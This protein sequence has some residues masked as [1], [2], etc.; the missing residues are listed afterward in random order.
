[1]TGAYEIKP[2]DLNQLVEETAETF[3][4]I[5]KQIVI[6]TE[7]AAD[8]FPVEADRGQIEQILLNLFVNAAEA[9]PD[10]G[11]LT[12]KTMNTTRDAIADKFYDPQSENYVLLMVTDSGM[13]MDEETMEHIFDPF[14]TTKPMGQGTGLGLASAYNI[15]K[16]HDGYIEVESTQGY[17][18]TFRIYLP[19][20]EKAV[21]KVITPI[22]ELIK[23][24]E[25][26]L[27]VDDEEAVLE[28]GKDL[29]EALGYTVLIAKDGK[30]G[31]HVYRTNQND[32]DLVLLD[33]V[34]PGMG[35]GKVYDRLKEI[36]P[37]I[38]VILSSGYSMGGAVT[39]ILNLGC[40]GFI[41]KPFT[42][43]ELS[44]KIREVLDRTE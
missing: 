37:E 40:H 6:H 39:D 21:E 4:R 13:G 11:D 19:A 28:A 36:N 42:M 34:M 15:I 10:G 5:K 26:V 8:L 32:I 2:I 38:K 41:Q 27:M 3:G 17:R 20:S 7:F 16:G 35:G 31:I 1:M 22:E 25:T 29:L 24:T 14:F 43:R 9:M 12:L 44:G 18:T 30:E 23:G 33:I